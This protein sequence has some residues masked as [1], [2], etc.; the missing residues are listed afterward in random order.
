MFRW[1]FLGKGHLR[2]GEN[3]EDSVSDQVAIAEEERDH[4][5]Y[6]SKRRMGGLRGNRSY[7]LKPSIPTFPSTK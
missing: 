6:L 7:F 5:R 1:E 3:T 4:G 2:S